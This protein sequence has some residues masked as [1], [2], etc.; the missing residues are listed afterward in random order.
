MKD[1]LDQGRQL[2]QSVAA[3]VGK[4]INPPLT[5]DATPRR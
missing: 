2:L 3:K 5:A 1:F 4:A